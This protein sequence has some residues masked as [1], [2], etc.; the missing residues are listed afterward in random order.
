MGVGKMKKNQYRTPV[1]LWTS[2]WKEINKEEKI[3]NSGKRYTVPVYALYG[4]YNKE[5][6]RKIK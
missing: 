1:V 4:T 2:F 3:T 6:T 5:Y